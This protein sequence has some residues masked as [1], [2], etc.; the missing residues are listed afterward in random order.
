M[1]ASLSEIYLIDAASLRFV[2]V[3]Q[4]ACANLRYPLQRLTEMTPL[5]L[6]P[7]LPAAQFS[8]LLDALGDEVG[9]HVCLIAAHLRSDGSSYPITLRLMRADRDGQE[10]SED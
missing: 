5:E 2:D 1:Q 8:A 9:A 3:N 4:A 6:A 10:P 7:K